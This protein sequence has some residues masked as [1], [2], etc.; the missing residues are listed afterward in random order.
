MTVDVTT[1]PAA[2]P[3]ALPLPEGWIALAPPGDDPAVW[4][5]EYLDGLR[6]QPSAPV[7]AELRYGLLT[8][9]EMTEG[10]RPG[11]RY[12]FAFLDFPAEGIVRS[13]L[14]VQMLRVTPDAIDN[15]RV[16]L[17]NADRRDEIQV[18]NRRVFDLELA[19]GTAVVL[20]DFTLS[21]EIEA[22]AEPAL[23][24][25]IAGL[26]VTGTDTMIEFALYAQDLTVF[27]DIVQYLV[28]IIGNFD[29]SGDN[30]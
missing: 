7:R 9:M 27:D 29:I 25:A 18:I 1:R 3:S 11:K 12:N 16:L 26:F 4:V 14:S 23:E 2:T 15:Y 8:M 21:A 6:D 30:Q 5:E 10:M 19:A 13:L 22:V 20:H 24:R 17:E 28:D